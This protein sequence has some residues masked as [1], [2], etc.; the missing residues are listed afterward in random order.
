MGHWLGFYKARWHMLSHFHSSWAPHLNQFN[1][2][3]VLKV[4]PRLSAAAK[5][6]TRADRRSRPREDGA[7]VP[8]A[9]SPSLMLIVT[10]L[11]SSLIVNC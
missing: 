1:M 3:N 4:M 5:G 11:F 6:P 2:D 8:V 7:V 10:P 9:S